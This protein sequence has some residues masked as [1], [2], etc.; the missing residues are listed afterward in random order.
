MTKEN[1]DYKWTKIENGIGYAAIVN[2]DA[3]SN[4]LNQNIVVTNYS[5]K[6][7]TGQG[8]IEEVPNDGYNSWKLAAKLGL[9]YAFSLTQQHW[10]VTINKIEGNH[11]A[12]NPA[13]IGYTILRAFFSKINIELDSQKIETLERFVLS[14]WTKP[15]KELIPDF[16]NLKFTEYTV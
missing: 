13:V 2:I 15:Y 9:E 6:G 11:T 10:I 3:I 8:S 16:F 14:S 5:G 4:S 7:F 1:I 12:T